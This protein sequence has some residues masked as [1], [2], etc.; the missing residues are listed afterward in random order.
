MV[1]GRKAGCR[2]VDHG[3]HAGK[4]NESGHEGT[5]LDVERADKV[6]DEDVECWG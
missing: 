3:L 4:V 2:R 5:G 6:G 1:G